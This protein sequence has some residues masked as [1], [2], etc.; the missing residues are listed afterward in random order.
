MRMMSG[1]SRHCPLGHLNFSYI[2]LVVW[3]EAYVDVFE[4]NLQESVL[5]FYHAGPGDLW[6]APLLT[7]FPPALPQPFIKVG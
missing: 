3:R 7:K 6:Q 4:N 1:I 2:Y 5:P